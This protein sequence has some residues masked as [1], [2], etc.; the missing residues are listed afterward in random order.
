MTRDQDHIHRFCGDPS[1]VTLM[2]LSAGCSSTTY[3]LVSP[4]S[5]GLFKLAAVITVSVALI[6]RHFPRRIIAQSGVGGFSPSYH[7][8]NEW[9]A[10]KYGNE[11]S[12]L[13]GCLDVL[14]RVQVI[15]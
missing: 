15:K 11:A 13:V 7:H 1:N 9:Q 3:H 2:G 10:V 4:K 8:Y 12:A 14:T 5:R 6:L